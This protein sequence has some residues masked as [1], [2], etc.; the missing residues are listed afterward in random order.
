ME[1]GTTEMNV[2]AKIYHKNMEKYTRYN[3]LVDN[4]INDN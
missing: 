2:D 3:Y 1:D 4:R